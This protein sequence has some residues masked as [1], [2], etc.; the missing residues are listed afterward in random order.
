M[1]RLE[2]GSENK[3][4]FVAAMQTTPGGQ[5]QLVCLRQQPFTREAAAVFAARSIAPSA[6]IVSDGL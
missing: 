1:A 3:V 5:P 4:P 6:C 2:H